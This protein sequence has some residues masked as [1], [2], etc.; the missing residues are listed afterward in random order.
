MPDIGAHLTHTLARAARW[1]DRTSEA[2]PKRA[3]SRLSTSPYSSRAC[4]K[5]VRAWFYH[6][7]QGLHMSVTKRKLFLM[8]TMMMSRKGG[9][10]A[11]LPKRAASRLSTSPCSS[12]AC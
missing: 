9:S 7:I 3:A 10:C 1:P 4:R 8:M 5:D 11:A 12:R 6:T 2:L